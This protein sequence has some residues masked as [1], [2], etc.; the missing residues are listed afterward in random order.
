MWKK[1]KFKYK[2]GLLILIPLFG[3]LIFG[4]QTIQRQPPAKSMKLKLILS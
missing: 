3:E 4:Y 1:I 2:L